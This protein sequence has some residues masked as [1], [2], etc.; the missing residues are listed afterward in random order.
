MQTLQFQRQKRRNVF[1][2]TVCVNIIA[3][4]FN[5]SPKDNGRCVTQIYSPSQNGIEPT[6]GVNYEI[7]V[8]GV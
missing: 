6:S 4:Y 7:Y 2:Q 5:Q 3:L 1:V 8:T